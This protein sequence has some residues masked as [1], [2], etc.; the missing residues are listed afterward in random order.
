MRGNQLSDNSNT[1]AGIV[2][3]REKTKFVKR[4]EQGDYLNRNSFLNSF[5]LS[6]MKFIWRLK[7]NQ[8]GKYNT[9]F[10]CQN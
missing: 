8:M 6:L 7:V 5:L 3:D 10:A 2:N 1:T 4:S 9:D